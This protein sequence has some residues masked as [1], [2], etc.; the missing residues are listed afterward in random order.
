MTDHGQGAEPIEPTN[1]D[2]DPTTADDGQT[3]EDTPDFSTGEGMV[4]LAGILLVGV[5]LI[6]EIFIGRYGITTV[7]VLLGA[8]AALVPRL[9]P[10]SVAKIMPMSTIMKILGYSIALIGVIE[11]I[12]DISIATS[13]YDNF[14][15]IVG[16]LI[17][18]AAYA[19][20]WVG[21]RQIET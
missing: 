18:Y 9:D 2:P 19:L 13:L 21:A 10:E 5:W 11:I 7:A 14:L 12:D 8:M 20:A 17:A 6:F 4:A 3:T 16:A 1:A 15:S